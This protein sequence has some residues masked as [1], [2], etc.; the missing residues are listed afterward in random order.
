MILRA[1]RYI[2]YIQSETEMLM[3]FFC[4]YCLRLMLMASYWLTHVV[5]IDGLNVMET[6]W[7]V[8]IELI[9]TVRNNLNELLFRRLFKRKSKE[10]HKR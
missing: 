2:L 9:R 7:I 10:Q 4:R 5:K 1:L 8:G 6:L 3:T